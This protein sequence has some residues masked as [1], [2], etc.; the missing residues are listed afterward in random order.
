MTTTNLDPLTAATFDSKKLVIGN[1]SEFKEYNFGKY[2]I[3]Y[4]Y[5]ASTNDKL[6][7]KLSGVT[8]RKA[9]P[10]LANS[11][12]S[13]KQYPKVFVLL[14]LADDD[15]V[16]ILEDIHQSM[17]EFMFENR[18][19]HFP[20]PSDYNSVE[21]VMDELKKEFVFRNS[22]NP[23]VIGVSFPLEGF[24]ASDNISIK[25]VY[26]DTNNP[27]AP[28]VKTCGSIDNMLT[29]GSVCD[30]FL[31]PQSMKVT[32]TGQY[33]L[34]L[35]IYHQINVTT[36]AAPGQ[37]GSSK[38]IPGV[39]C[40][41]IDLDTFTLGD[42][43]KNDQGGKKLKPK[44]SY[45]TSKGEDKFR[46]VTLNITD[47]EV[48]LA[49]NENK[50]DN[51]NVTYAWSMNLR[52]E[53]DQADVIDAIEQKC[54]DL[55]SENYK[56][57]KGSAKPKSYKKGN[58]KKSRFRTALRDPTD[59]TSKRSI[60][61]SV[62]CKEPGSAVPSFC[63]NFF[64]PGSEE[65]TYTDEEVVNDIANQRHTGVS[66]TIYIKHIWYC[67]DYDSVKWSLGHATIDVTDTG[68]NFNTGDT[69]DVFKDVTNANAADD[70]TDQ[71]T[72]GG[73]SSAFNDVGTSN[74]TTTKDDSDND[75]DN[76]NADDNGKSEQDDSSDAED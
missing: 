20:D 58:D 19:K 11:D 36:Y 32:S 13:S 66:M 45:T 34:Q 44:M 54:Y 59:K 7:I 52:L 39:D 35:G 27:P 10:P 37:G 72:L 64:K 28:D 29:P 68:A 71:P 15:Q 25:V 55:M 49:R 23:R 12:G 67:V 76:D 2:K 48:Y 31:V 18:D 75:S 50:D 61:L 73:A 53:D 69:S 22:D 47:G 17:A 62:Y 43:I 46:G 6:V 40:D 60:Y 4:K 21:D 41:K 30:I 57:Y 63:D 9:F 33:N 70:D 16:K 56:K 42:I 51:G 24:T 3:A 1:Y 38:K 65:E 74:E 8:I 26:K 5:S 14:E